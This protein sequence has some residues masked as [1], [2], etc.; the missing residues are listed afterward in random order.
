MAAIDD[1]IENL[2]SSLGITSAQ[3][4]DVARALGRLNTATTKN[5]FA[6]DAERKATEQLTDN[7]NSLRRSGTQVGTAFNAT[8]SGM[9]N[10]SSSITGSGAAFTAI[11]PILNTMQT[12]IGSMTAS[13]GAFSGGLLGMIPILGSGLKAVTEKVAAGI[14]KSV[15]IIFSAATAQVS[16]TQ[17]LANS[18]LTLSNSGMIFGGSLTKAQEQAAAAGMSLE[19]FASFATKNASALAMLSGN[20]QT[21]A[22]NVARISKDLGPGLVSL[23]GGFENLGSA[24]AD[25]MAMQTMVGKDAVKD[26][27]LLTEGAK[28]YLL[29]QKE[30]SN[31][32]GKDVTRLKQEQE[33]RL[34]VAAYQAKLGEMSGDQAQQTQNSISRIIA[35]YG[36]D[37]GQVAMELVANNGEILSIAGQKIQAMAPALVD[38]VRKTL[39]AAQG[40]Q[41]SYQKTQA[42]LMVEGAAII[43]QYQSEFRTELQL[44]ASGYDVSGIF[45]MKNDMVAAGIAASSALNNAAQA[46]T[47]ATASTN[48]A[49]KKTYDPKNEKDRDSVF[50][51][52]ITELENF[53]IK[54]N[55]LT[56]EYLPATATSLKLAYQAA[57][58]FAE[59]LH[60]LADVTKFMLGEMSGPEL[61]RRLGL[62]EGSEPPAPLT[63]AEQ[64]N[65][66]ERRRRRT[67]QPTMPYDPRFDPNSPDYAGPR[68]PPATP[69]SASPDPNRSQSRTEPDAAEQRTAALQLEIE[70]LT[71]EMADLRNNSQPNNRDA[72]E[73]N[74][75]I[76]RELQEHTTLLQ[77]IRD[78]Q[79]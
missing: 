79:A 32:T 37:F 76:L 30:L 13:F 77:R 7:L 38:N 5:V 49:M 45:K 14:G 58:L 24:V 35:T 39:D 52:A 55:N 67:G 8:V 28:A 19:T 17:Q 6:T 70:R 43:K 54:M 29:N 68:D 15:D 36:Q 64:Q 62:T 2:R 11:I 59:S 61:A 65:N 16:A 9:T 1:T 51:M 18:F 48:A 12:V 40:D 50:T 33:A 57:D 75:A 73:R 23:Y 41:A 31:L 27:K 60:K 4:D 10:L 20:A 69:G 53:K 3:A 22:I 42:A 47:E 66:A 71:R 21:S 63:P 25:Y 46:Q 74:V 78:G 26:Q 34:K 56:I 44:F 72:D